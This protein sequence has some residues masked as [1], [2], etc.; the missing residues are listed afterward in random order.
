[1][2][3]LTPGERAKHWSS[4]FMALWPAWVF[5]LGLLGYTNKEEIKGF[6]VTKNEII[7]TLTPFQQHMREEIE[8]IDLEE[9]TGRA[10][11][12]A[13]LEEIKNQ[14]ARKDRANHQSVVK[15]HEALEAKVNRIEQLVN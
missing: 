9:A 3:K 8:R 2:G 13:E 7:T 12:A 14:L 10:E 5:V 11:I 6:M 15:K 1:M 4:A